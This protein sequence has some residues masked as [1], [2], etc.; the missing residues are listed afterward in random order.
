M[1]HN[2]TLYRDVFRQLTSC[3]G[4]VLLFL[5]ILD[6][7]HGEY[8]FPLYFIGIPV[9]LA[10]FMMIERYCYNLVLYVLL[11][12]LCFMPFLFVHGMDPYYRN[13][14][15]VMLGVESARSLH[16]W[17]NGLDQP[18]ND[19]PWHL[20]TIS[21]LSYPIAHYYH[22]PALETGSYLVGLFVLTIHFIRFYIT[23]LDNLMSRSKLVTSMPTKRIMSTNLALFGFFLLTFLILAGCNSLLGFE[24]IFYTLGKFLVKCICVLL[25]LVLV[26]VGILRAL[27]AKN[28]VA[29]EIQEP[30]AA[31]EESFAQ[32]TE[33]SL[34][35]EIFSRLFTLCA[36]L[37]F[38]LLLYHVVSEFIKR[39][40]IRHA[41]DTDIIAPIAKENGRIEK[42][43]KKAFKRKRQG[44]FFAKTYAERIRLAY[45]QK[46]LT[47][48]EIQLECFDTAK[49]IAHKVNTMYDENIDTMTSVYEKARYSDEPVTPDEAKQGGLIC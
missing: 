12:G 15:L 5:T 36:L 32:A 16:I 28:T 37:L 48:R 34:L 49:D 35:A 26:I 4:Y 23:G 29:E 42:T 46:I 31:L 1:N 41:K 27:T 11:H 20:L 43:K 14:Y 25:Q 45:R 2:L 3:C 33:P 39:Y 44:P 24:Q 6:L 9:I 18:Y 38:I 13:L 21:A 30:V 47:Y 8:I 40:L 17:K 7:Y 19:V 22:L 10:V